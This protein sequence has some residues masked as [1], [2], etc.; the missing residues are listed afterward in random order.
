MAVGKI[1]YNGGSGV[2]GAVEATYKIHADSEDIKAGNFVEKVGVEEIQ[3]QLV[4][5]IVLNTDVSQN[6]SMVEVRNNRILTA[7]CEQDLCTFRLY[8][9]TGNVVPVLL[10]EYVYA[11][12]VISI[13]MVKLKDDLIAVACDIGSTSV[14]AFALSTKNDVITKGEST[15]VIGQSGVTVKIA[16]FNSSRFVVYGRRSNRNLHVISYLVDQD[17]KLSSASQSELYYEVLD[18]SMSFK[19]VVS[20]KVICV[21]NTI[22]PSVGVDISIFTYTDSSRKI[23]KAGN[24]M[25]SSDGA[26]PNDIVV[27]SST[28]ALVVYKSNANTLNAGIITMNASATSGTLQLTKNYILSTNSGDVT[29]LKIA[30]YETSKY[31]LV[32]NG[33]AE[34][35]NVTDDSVSLGANKVVSVVGND[36]NVAVPMTNRVCVLYK[37]SNNYPTLTQLSANDNVISN[38]INYIAYTYQMKKATSTIDGVA[39]KGGQ[40]GDEIV[41][42]TL[43][44]NT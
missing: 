11:E 20:N 30:E 32:Y 37:N 38:E 26:Y 3:T 43:G 36:I 31:M 28:K 19:N 17:L 13:D 41:I 42:Y 22:D 34:L 16:K 2:K 40:A 10:K 15:A 27:L 35:L 24:M 21:N 25:I 33:K 5:D 6:I 4:P 7:T 18:D 9:T 29:A 8:D 44:G 1:S 39:K 14:N 23:L 12:S